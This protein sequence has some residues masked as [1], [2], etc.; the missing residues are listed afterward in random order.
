MPHKPQSRVKTITLESIEQFHSSLSERGLA[1]NT[2]QAYRTDLRTFLE[3][4][5]GHVSAADFKSCASY[6]LNQSRKTLS[7]STTLRR[8]CSLRAFAKWAGFKDNLDDY[9]S[10]A[11]PPHKPHPIVEGMPGVIRM[12]DSAEDHEWQAR[13]LITLC[14]MCG[15][16]IGE[17]LT[18]RASSINTGNMML[19]VRGKGD[20]TRRVA[21]SAEAWAVLNEAYCRSL[22]RD[23]VPLVGI[24]YRVARRTVTALG[25][26]ARLMRRVAS[27]DL[28]ATFATD[29]MN[30]GVN[31]RIIQELLGHASL[32][33]TAAYLGVTDTQ[34]HEA[35]N[36]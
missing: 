27:H 25:R 34:L 22:L 9:R 28:R 33:V 32:A 5:D 11:K 6:W 24:G 35:V 21:I 10:P 20:K 12:L 23:D 1:Q 26:R 31:L 3:S 30:K 16:R 19:T 36:R 2:M 4:C 7:T 15:L 8:L 13:A 14:G 17:A 18:I 29:L